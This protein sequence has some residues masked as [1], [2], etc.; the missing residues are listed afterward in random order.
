M[1]DLFILEA[2]KLVMKTKDDVFPSVLALSGMCRV[3]A[4]MF[5]QKGAL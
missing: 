5:R 2:Q 3:I 4:A 1:C